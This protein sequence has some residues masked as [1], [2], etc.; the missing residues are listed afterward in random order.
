[1]TAPMQHARKFGREIGTA[2]AVLA[3]YLLTVLGPLHHA[4]ATQLDFAA[5]GYATT[6]TGWVLC[7]PAG[8]AGDT[9]Q[10]IVSKCPA[11][12]IAKQDM[13]E[14]SPAVIALDLRQTMLVAPL[15]PVTA[16]ITPEPM[17]PP[18]GSRAP[19]VAV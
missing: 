18:S 6:Q 13:V 16:G 1:M 4:R 7:T 15:V 5:L 3:I 12:G 17:S 14:P 2:F 10:V 11:A 8:T 9:G 19:P